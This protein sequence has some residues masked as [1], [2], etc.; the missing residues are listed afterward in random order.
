LSSPGL[1]IFAS[2]YSSFIVTCNYDYCK[3]CFLSIFNKFTKEI[4]AFIWL[5]T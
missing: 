1:Q 4:K 3:T 5:I 2:F